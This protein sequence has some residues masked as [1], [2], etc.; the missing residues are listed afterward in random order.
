MVCDM[1]LTQLVL[2]VL[3]ESHRGRMIFRKVGGF[4]YVMSVLVS[5]EGALADPPVSQWHAGQYDRLA[6]SHRR[7]YTL[8]SVESI[9]IFVLSPP[10]SFSECITFLSHL[11]VRSFICRNNIV[12]KIFNE[13]F[14][15]SR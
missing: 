15:Q 9:A 10:N 14:E 8:V 2:S 3:R 6:V 5:M 1:L 4:V 12:T 13:W 11:F 7:M